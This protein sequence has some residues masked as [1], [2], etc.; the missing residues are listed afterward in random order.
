MTIKEI[1]LAASMLQY[2]SS[3]GDAVEWKD[4]PEEIWEGWTMPERRKIIREFYRHGN[5][6]VTSEERKETNL[7]C[8]QLMQLLAYK[9]ERDFRYNLKDG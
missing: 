7:I 8:F 4:V 1:R 2:A 5:G 3:Q 9:M 6:M